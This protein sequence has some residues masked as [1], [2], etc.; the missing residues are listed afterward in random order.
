MDTASDSVVKLL[1]SSRDDV[2]MSL[3]FNEHRVNEI[4]VNSKDNQQDIDLYVRAELSRRIKQN[5]I[6]LLWG[7]AV[8]TR[9]QEIIINKLSID[10]QGM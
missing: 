6:Q 10:A 4:H 3:F 8:P 1:V 2:S 5:E 9:L 7:Q